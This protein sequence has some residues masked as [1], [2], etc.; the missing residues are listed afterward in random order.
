MSDEGTKSASEATSAPGIPATFQPTSVASSTPGPGA[1]RAMA[2]RSMKSRALIQPR[3]STAFWM[4][5]RMLGPPPIDSS[6]SGMKTIASAISGLSRI[7]APRGE[8]SEQEAGRRHAQHH[9]HHRPAQHA[10]RHE[11][12]QQDRHRAEAPLDPPA[13]LDAD[14]DGQPDPRGRHPV[15]AGAQPRAA[16]HALIAPA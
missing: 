11:Q 8:P 7:A 1:A 14:Q 10:D 13:R 6:D 15:R 9:R 3:A 12:Q 2:K 4:P 16:G 5:A